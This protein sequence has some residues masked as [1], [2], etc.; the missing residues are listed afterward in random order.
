[1]FVEDGPEEAEAQGVQPGRLA[2]P[3][4]DIRCPTQFMLVRDRIVRD[5]CWGGAADNNI[6][7][8]GI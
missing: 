6:R 5:R 3:D 2:A 7:S 4:I 8:G 1:V